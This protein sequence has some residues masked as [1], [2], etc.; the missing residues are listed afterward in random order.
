MKCESSL[1]PVYCRDEERACLSCQ[2][3]LDSPDT[4]ALAELDH[5]Y[6]DIVRKLIPNNGTLSRFYFCRKLPIYLL[7][8]AR[9]YLPYAVSSLTVHAV[10]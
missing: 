5:R 9:H 10:R 4:L 3:A 2:C 7:Y 1:S 6:C 8:T